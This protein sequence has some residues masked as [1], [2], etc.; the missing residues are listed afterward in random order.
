MNQIINLAAKY[1]YMFGGRFDVPMLIRMIVGRSLGQGAQ[2]SQSLQSLFAH[3]PGL[4]VVM[5]A[6]SQTILDT[7]PT[8]IAEYRGPVISFE[9]RLMYDLNFHVDSRTINHRGDPFG[10]HGGTPRKY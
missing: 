4:K 10:S 6:S 3:I 5:P 1:K 7:Y 8:I 9:H 2:H